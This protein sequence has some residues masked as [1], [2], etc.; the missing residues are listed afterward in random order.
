MSRTGFAPTC[1]TFVQR[2]RVFAATVCVWRLLRMDSRPKCKAI[3][4]RPPIRQCGFLRNH[5]ALLPEYA[6]SAPSAATSTDV[7]GKY[8]PY[9]VLTVKVGCLDGL[10]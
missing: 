1:L 5:C 9:R 6:D 4:G 2:L 7:Q 8:R 3:E 10:S